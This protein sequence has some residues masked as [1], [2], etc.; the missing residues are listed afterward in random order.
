MAILFLHSGQPSVDLLK[1]AAD[2]SVVFSITYTPDQWDWVIR[3]GNVTGPEVPSIEL[4]TASALKRLYS[5][6]DA[7]KCF[8]VN[9][10]Q[11]LPRSSQMISRGAVAY[12]IHLVDMNP[13]SVSLYRNGKFRTISDC[14][15]P[16]ID[17]AIRLARKALYCLGLHFGRVDLGY[18]E[19][20]KLCVLSVSAAP[21]VTKQLAERYMSALLVAI[22]HRLSSESIASISVVLGADPEFMMISPS[23]KRIIFASDFFP[24]EGVVGYDNQSYFRDRRNHPIAELRP[25]PSSSPTQLVRELKEALERAA[26]KTQR[27]NCLW[28]AGSAPVKGYSIGG[29][30]HFTGVPL[31]FDLVKAFDN[32]LAIPCML[33]EHPKRAAMRRPKYGFLGDVRTKAHGGF[34][35][36]TPSSWLVSRRIAE[37]I[38]YLAKLV[39]VE[40]KNLKGDF[41]WSIDAVE[42]FYKARKRRFRL[43]IGK[44]WSDIE[45]TQYY[46]KCCQKIL[47]IKKLIDSKRIWREQSDIRKSWGIHS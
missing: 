10:V 31:T 43:I 37:A 14:T 22:K 1:K 3:W 29:H 32:Y 34:E 12:R 21:K 26:E 30:I 19:K 42:D 38:L 44:L 11:F 39:A 45:R 15:T 36:R 13:I 23:T 40:H 41:L 47:V 28:L 4:N 16:R 46:Q 7:A 2:E 24:R 5:R 27:T 25:S 18:T 17:K 33:I 35:Y 9:R 20:G 8:A 6:T